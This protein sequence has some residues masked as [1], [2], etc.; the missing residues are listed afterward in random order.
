MTYDEF[1]NTPFKNDGEGNP[2]ALK[3]VLPTLTRPQMKYI[4]SRLKK[5]RIVHIEEI[6]NIGED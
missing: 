4:Q 1:M 5:G 3:D 6:F 2:V